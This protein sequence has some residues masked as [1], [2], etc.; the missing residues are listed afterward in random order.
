[1]STILYN[2]TGQRIAKLARMDEDVFHSDDLANLWEIKDANNL[3][4]TLKRYHQ[5]GLLKRIYKGMYCLKNLEDLDPYLLGTKALH[6]F[7]YI[8]TETILFIHGIINRKPSYITMISSKSQKFQI[9]KYK[10]T[11]RQLKDEFLYNP[12]GI[13]QKN[14]YRIASIERA[15]A[16]TIYF[17][18]YSQFDA[19]NLID[20][21]KIQKIQKS[22]GYPQ[23]T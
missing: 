9:Y 1:M 4:T 20:W 16:D 23:S 10:Y 2:V 3:H 11:S 14:G 17:N 6:R 8:S 18:P 19:T 7:T 15:I 22:I 5:K 21:N 13:N 12:I